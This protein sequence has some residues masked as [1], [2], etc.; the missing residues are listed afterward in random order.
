MYSPGYVATSS[1]Q[2][3]AGN[4]LFVYEVIGLGQSTTADGLDYPV[5]RSGSTFITVPLKR[6]NQEMRRITRM[7]GQIV[8]IRPLEGDSPLPNTEG[9]PKPS[10]AEGNGSEVAASSAPESNKSMTTTPK[11][12]KTTFPS[13]FTVPKLPTQVK[14]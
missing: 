10:Q 14:F 8:N 12:K 2:S 4:R 13:I 1:R 3:D 9:M 6:M 11:E 5:R 7:G